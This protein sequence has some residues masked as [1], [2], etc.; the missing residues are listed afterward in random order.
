MNLLTELVCNI[1]VS[2]KQYPGAAA[3]DLCMSFSVGMSGS[4][5]LPRK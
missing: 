3:Y 4:M 2:L 1:L 5:P